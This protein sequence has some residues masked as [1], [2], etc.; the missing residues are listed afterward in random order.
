MRLVEL[1]FRSYPRTNRAAVRGRHSA[2]DSACEFSADGRRGPRVQRSRLVCLRLRLP[3]ATLSSMARPICRAIGIRGSMRNSIAAS[4][5]RCDHGSGPRACAVL[6]GPAASKAIPLA[7]AAPDSFGDVKQT[8][9][10]LN[11]AAR[12][13]ATPPGRRLL[14]GPAVCPFRGRRGSEGHAASGGARGRTR[15]GR[16]SRRRMPV[17]SRLG[18][19]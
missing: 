14:F 3:R 4:G 5:G 1:S 17:E 19:G 8:A 7:R 2:A 18:T 15:A 11:G 6:K 16:P 12:W 10:P 9:T 13:S